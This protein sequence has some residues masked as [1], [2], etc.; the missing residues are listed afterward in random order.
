MHFY[1]FFLFFR[2]AKKEKANKANP[3]VLSTVIPILLLPVHKQDPVQSPVFPKILPKPNSRA[4]EASLSN[5]E[6]G[7][8]NKVTE[9]SQSRETFVKETNSRQEAM[10]QTDIYGINS[11]SVSGINKGNYPVTDGRQ[12]TGIGNNNMRTNSSNSLGQVESGTQVDGA[13]MSHPSPKGRRKS[14]KRRSS[15]ARPASPRRKQCK[16]STGMQTSLSLTQRKRKQIVSATQTTGDLI[17]KK[18][19]AEADIPISKRTV[20]SQVTPEKPR[21]HF[22]TTNVGTETLFEVSDSFMK[23]SMPILRDTYS[24]VNT[25]TKPLLVDS[26]SQVKHRNILAETSKSLAESQTMTDLPESISTQTFQ[27][28]LVNLH[29]SQGN[30]MENISTASACTQSNNVAEERNSAEVLYA[31]P[32]QISKRKSKETIVQIYND[33]L[34]EPVT[35]LV[36]VEDSNSYSDRQKDKK[37]AKSLLRRDVSN[38][39]TISLNRRYTNLSS[40]NRSYERENNNMV[41][42]NLVGPVTLL[43]LP[44]DSNINVQENLSQNI[45]SQDQYQHAEGLTAD[46]EAQAMSAQEFQKLLL[47]SGIDLEDASSNHNWA[48]NACATEMFGEKDQQFE[49]SFDFFSSQTDTIDMNTQTVSDLDLFDSIG[50]I[51]MNTQT[52]GPDV[53]FLDLVM[54]NM[55][56]QTFTDEDDVAHRGLSNSDDNLIDM[57]PRVHSFGVHTRDLSMRSKATSPRIKT[58]GDCNY[59]LPLQYES[60]THSLGVGTSDF[61]LDTGFNSSDIFQCPVDDKGQNNFGDILCSTKPKTTTQSIGCGEGK[62]TVQ[63][64]T[65]TT[66]SEA[67]DH[68]VHTEMQTQVDSN[69]IDFEVTNMQTQTTFDDFYNWLI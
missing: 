36:H 60:E 57:V 69:D 46:T 39:Q 35:M 23:R 18:A 21:N 24:Q 66:G 27:S 42:N 43:C 9:L 1:Y 16:I 17:L 47:S 51:D 59:S 6:Q 68:L 37:Q 33:R 56:T 50:A 34:E 54:N 55:E 5:I 67:G 49:S 38:R 65:Q 13:V 40:E 62:A 53:D 14:F 45:Q 20:G 58:N 4:K 8:S 15:Q 25:L 2:N 11:L 3:S 29:G 44:P 19:M 22:G 48:S 61:D 26:Y 52:T 63:T 32:V 41:E 31:K 30:K 28:Y 12:A 10:I 7:N 64:E